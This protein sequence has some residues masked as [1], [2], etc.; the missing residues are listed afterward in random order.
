MPREP[1]LRLF[2]DVDFSALE[3]GRATFRRLTRP[4]P[5][6]LGT[7]LIVLMFA[8]GAVVVFAPVGL[9]VADSDSQRLFFAVCGVLAL[10]AFVGPMLAFL[11]WNRL[12][13]RPMIDAAGK[14]GRFA[15]ANA[16]DYRPQTIEE[17]ELPAPAGQEG[18]TQRVRHRLHPAPD[19]PLPP[20]EI[21]YRFFH[22][23][24]PADFRPTTE[25][26]Y[27]VTLEYG[28]YV[29]VPLPR[30]L[31]H[32][33]LLRRED[34]DDSDLD[35]GA[36]YSMGLEFD[37]TFTLLCPPGYERDAL[38]LFTPDV[39]AAMLDDAGAAQFG[40]EVLDDRL[41]FRFPINSFPA[42]LFSADVRRAFLLVERTAAEL[43]K[44]ASRYRD[45]R[46]GDAQLN[47]VDESGRRMGT[48]K[49]RTAVIAGVGVPL[50]IL[51]PFTMLMF[52][53]LAL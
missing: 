35:H 46:V 24:V 38:Y 31:P 42:L 16:F 39:M 14:L 48:R 30:R 27:P 53:M 41:F 6:R 22:R 3:T 5:S 10:A 11:V 52:G 4:F 28:W 32:I 1:E 43:T 2:R 37:R 47:L 8:A 49:R 12:H 25:T 19:S 15:E 23:P 34:V 20:F 44:Q 40:A 36:R 33:A 7:A 9:F 51:A 26:P 18:M 45:S 17:G 29:A 50:M 21:G 13:G